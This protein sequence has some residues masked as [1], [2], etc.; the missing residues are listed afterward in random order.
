[1]PAHFPQF[2]QLSKKNGIE[3]EKYSFG[4]TKKYGENMK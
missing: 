3:D 1:M 4:E 2:P